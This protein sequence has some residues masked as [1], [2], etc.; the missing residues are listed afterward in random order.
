MQENPRNRQNEQEDLSPGNCLDAEVASLPAVAKKRA[1]L[2]EK[3]EIFTIYDLLSF[4]PRDYTDWTKLIPISALTDKEEASFLAIVRRKPSLLR[5]GRMTILRTILSDES[6]SIRA[7]WFNQP[8]YE[9]KLVKD[10][11][12]YFRG[13]VRRDG[14]NFDVT[15]PS[16]VSVSDTEANVL[17][18]Y[19]LTKA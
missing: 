11:A 13:K 19:P 8:Y 12:F 17:P 1:K 7:T 2:L 10:G 6:G 9:N 14:V 4:F 3:L 16:F 5:K 15:N 18:V